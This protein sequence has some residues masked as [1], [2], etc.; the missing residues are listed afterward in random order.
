VRSSLSTALSETIVSDHDIR[1]VELAITFR[2]V[3]HPFDKR[4]GVENNACE[5][6]RANG[7][8]KI[9]QPRP[10]WPRTNLWMPSVPSKMAHSPAANF[11]LPASLIRQYSASSSS[12]RSQSSRRFSALW[13]AP[14]RILGNRRMGANRCPAVETVLF[15][16]R[17]PL[18]TRSCLA[19]RIGRMSAVIRAHMQKSPCSAG[20]TSS[21][22]ASGAMNTRPHFGAGHLSADF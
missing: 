11:L 15:L 16:L 17:R 10:V 22:G 18:T 8:Q 14:L 20:R 3:D 4:K 21:V 19:P 2:E 9:N 1:P 12:S 7:Q 6:A 5:A 13:A